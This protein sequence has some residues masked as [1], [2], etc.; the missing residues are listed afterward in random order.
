MDHDLGRHDVAQLFISAA[1]VAVGVGAAAV[2]ESS[3]A[4][5]PRAAAVTAAV[6]VTGVT[7]GALVVVDVTNRRSTDAASD[8]ADGN[9]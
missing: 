9:P 6:V 3:G 8:D 1:I 5:T 2:L 4:W 7:I